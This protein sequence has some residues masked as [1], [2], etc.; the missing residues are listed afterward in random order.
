MW[1]FDMTVFSHST[2]PRT[3]PQLPDAKHSE[4][5]DITLLRKKNQN[6]FKKWKKERKALPGVHTCWHG[7]VCCCGPF[8]ALITSTHLWG[9][10]R[11]GKEKVGSTLHIKSNKHTEILLLLWKLALILSNLKLNHYSSQAACWGLLCIPSPCKE[12]QMQA[13]PLGPCMLPGENFY[14]VQEGLQRGGKGT[15]GSNL[16]T[17]CCP[18]VHLRGLAL[19]FLQVTGNQG[20]QDHQHLEAGK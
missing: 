15:H 12:N 20:F 6:C 16:L 19:Q 2:V 18:S 11:P 9:C 5:W 3:L 13:Q 17:S 10:H 8:M 14:T 7:V 1:S 4:Q